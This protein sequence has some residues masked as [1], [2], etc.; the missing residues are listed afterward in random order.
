MFQNNEHLLHAAVA[1]ELAKQMLSGELQPGAVLPDI[2]TL[3]ARFGASRTALREAIKILTA[4]GMVTSAPRVGV[5]VRPRRQ[6]ELLDTD[7]MRW[8]IE[9]GLDRE[10]IYDILTMRRIIEPGAVELAAEY[11]S[12]TALKRIRALF[13]RLEA[14]LDKDLDAFIIA[15][16]H[17]HR[18]ILLASGSELLSQMEQLIEIAIICVATSTAHIPG[19]S[20]LG[21]TVHGEIVDAL[22]ARESK[23]AHWLMRDLVDMTVTKVGELFE[24]TESEVTTRVGEVSAHARRL[25][26]IISSTRETTESLRSTAPYLDVI[27]KET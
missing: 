20:R 8:R 19:G 5:K 22:E 9:V 3:G 27:Q 4:K 23:K 6:W 12:D 17:F 16:A 15:D 10:F 7:V 1:R 26:E 14:T 24:G 21:M 11:A 2:E 18:G 13:Q 25:L